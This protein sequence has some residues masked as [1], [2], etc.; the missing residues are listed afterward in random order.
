M[1]EMHRPWAGKKKIAKKD[2]TTNE[3]IEKA[4]ENR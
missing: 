3:G 2:S 1:T 4:G